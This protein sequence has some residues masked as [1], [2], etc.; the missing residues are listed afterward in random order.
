MATVPWEITHSVETNA[1][2]AFA[3]NFWTDVANWDDPPAE[4]ELDGAF[5]TG[6]RGATRLPGQ[7]PLNP[8][9]KLPDLAIQV[10]H[11]NEGK[12]SNYILSDYLAKISSEFLAVAGRGE[13][14]KWPIGMSFQRS[15]D[16][17]AKLR[18]TLGAIRLHGAKPRSKLRS[19]HGKHQECRG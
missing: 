9:M 4:F 11:R 18:R 15:Q 3:W 14:P 5:A 8:D 1:S 16:L 10:L 19:L 6:S 13:S 12:G 2:P 7:E 17:V